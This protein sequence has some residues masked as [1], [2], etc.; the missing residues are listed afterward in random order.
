MF[1]LDVAIRNLSGMIPDR[2]RIDSGS[3]KMG[4]VLRNPYPSGVCAENEPH[5]QGEAIKRGKAKGTGLDSKAYRAPS[6]ITDFYQ[7]EKR[8][9]ARFGNRG[10]SPFVRH[11]F[12]WPRDQE[13]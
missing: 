10:A 1:F 11:S 13:L 9:A 7:T 8:D 2:F 3:K 12:I 4:A 6:R 5:R